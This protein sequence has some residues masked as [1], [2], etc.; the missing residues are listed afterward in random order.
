MPQ[1]PPDPFIEGRYIV[2]LI[3]L[4]EGVRIVSN[5]LNIDPDDVTIGMPVEVA[6]ETFDGDVVL[7]QF[8][9]EV[10]L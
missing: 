3:Q 6:F 4:E 8:R 10:V 2:A 7:H 5:L 1:H 9:P